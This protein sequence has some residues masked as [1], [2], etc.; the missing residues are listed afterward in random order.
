MLHARCESPSNVCLQRTGS[1]K[2]VWEI[3]PLES[4]PAV[5]NNLAISQFSE[6]TTNNRLEDGTLD[7]PGAGASYR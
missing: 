3:Q 7:S 5:F 4:R 6:A 1:E 2:Q